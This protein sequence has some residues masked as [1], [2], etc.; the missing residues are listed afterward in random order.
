MLLDGAYRR[1][2]VIVCSVVVSLLCVEVMVKYYAFET[3]LML[4]VSCVE[5]SCIEWGLE[6]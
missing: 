4:G 5:V 6:R 3:I 1:Y 2:V